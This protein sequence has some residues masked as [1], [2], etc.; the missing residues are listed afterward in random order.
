[1]RRNHNFYLDT[2]AVFRKRQL[3]LVVNKT[4]AIR[5]LH[6]YHLIKM[7]LVQYKPVRL[8]PPHDKTRLSWKRPYNHTPP[9]LLFQ[10]HLHDTRLQPTVS[11]NDIHLLTNFHLIHMTIRGY[12]VPWLTTH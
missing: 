12:W 5:H 3:E 10:Y 9:F 1:M 7:P 11:I 2:C 6:P 4:T 8:Q